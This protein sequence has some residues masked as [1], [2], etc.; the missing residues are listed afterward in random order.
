MILSRVQAKGAALSLS[1]NSAARPFYLSICILTS[2]THICHSCQIS[3]RFGKNSSSSPS[4]SFHPLNGFAPN[5][6][7]SSMITAP[8]VG[9]VRDPHIISSLMHIISQPGVIYFFLLMTYF[10]KIFCPS[11]IQTPLFIAF[12][13]ILTPSMP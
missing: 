4:L 12:S 11:I 13:L 9:C 1:P 7:P 2:A 10:F 6:E 3:S 5:S 8:S